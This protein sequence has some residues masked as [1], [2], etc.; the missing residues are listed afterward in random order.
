MNVPTVPLAFSAAFAKGASD[1]YRSCQPTKDIA[2]IAIKIYITIVT[3]ID[4]IRA[5]SSAIFTI[6]SNPKKAKNINPAAENI[7]PSIKLGCRLDGEL[8]FGASK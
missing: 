6:F 1:M 5:F 4:I 2:D 7:N 8:L 3:I